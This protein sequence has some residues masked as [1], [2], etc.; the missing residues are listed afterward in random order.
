MSQHL[1]RQVEPFFCQKEMTEEVLQSH[2]EYQVSKLIADLR[3]KIEKNVPEKGDYKKVVYTE[4]QNSDKTLDVAFFRLKVTLNPSKNDDGLNS[5]FL[6]FA[7][8]QQG[9]PYFCEICVGAGT[10]QQILDA[11]S[12]STLPERL[13]KLMARISDDLNYE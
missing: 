7:G 6:D 12:V 13:I 2:V 8:Y 10:K 3:V 1:N 4:L 9:N 5:Y 11:L